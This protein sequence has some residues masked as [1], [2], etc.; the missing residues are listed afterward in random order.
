MIAYLDALKIIQHAATPPVAT[1]VQTSDA[2]NH[3]LA[4]DFSAPFALPRFDN[5]SMDGFA[6]RAQDTVTAS[7]QTPL[8]LPVLRAQAA[9]DVAG[10]NQAGSTVEIM[11]GAAMPLHA[12]A[13]IPIENV[14][15]LCDAQ[16]DITHITLNQPV[17][18]HDNVRFAGEDFTAGQTLITAGTLITPAH[19]GILYATGTTRINVYPM[20][21]V[22][23]FTTGK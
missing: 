6:L 19:L 4:E 11:T 1:P 18:L 3:V 17:P 9:G 21:S 8:T 7:L 20:P 13:V 5:S 2:L 12:D 14:S 10:S 22:S 16:G 23:I 15:T